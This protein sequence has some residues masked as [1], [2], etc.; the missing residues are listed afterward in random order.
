MSDAVF[1]ALVAAGAALLVGAL[2]A[3]PLRASAPRTFAAMALGIPLLA[4]ALYQLVGTPAALAPAPRMAAADGA[5]PAPT[6]AGAVAALEAELER[7]PRQ[8]EGWRLLGRGRAQLGDQGA[9]RDAFARAAALAPDDDDAQVE[10][11]EARARAS[12]GRR[13]DAE[14]TALLR[15]VLARSPDHQRARWF[16]GIAQRQAGDDAGAAET[17]APLL[18]RVDA[19]T[20]ASL[21]TQIDSARA[22]AGLPPLPPDATDDD[23]A[24]GALTVRVRL[25]PGLAA[26]GGIRDDATVFVIARVP[27]GPP[28]PVAA[29]R[30]AARDLPFVVTLDDR[31]GPMP[32]RKLS[33][34]SEVEVVA[35]ISTTGD[36]TRAPGDPESR[37]VVV[38]LPARGPVDLEIVAPR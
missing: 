25:A 6:L 36:A 35:R 28:M 26:R 3:W 14:A 1:F 8:V 16:L 38:S 23:A 21:R 37:P 11:A 18:S 34:V 15:A 13:F 17:W 20:A 7:D 5:D 10:Y 24:P 19:G 31:D 9:A 32:T 30:R 12:E 2:V 29:V 33:A 27:G 22:D 4:L